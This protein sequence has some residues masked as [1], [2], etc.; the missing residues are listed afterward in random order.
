MNSH[1]RVLVTAGNTRERIDNVRDW[2]NIFTGNTGLEI[3][4]AIAATGAEVDLLTS[5]A[6][7]RE[8]VAQH[9]GEDARIRPIAFG[10]HAQLHQALQARVTTERYDAVFMT[11]AVADYRPAGGYQVINRTLRDDGTEMWIV[12]SAQAGKIKSNFDQIAF[13]GERTQ[14]L[15]DLFRS[16]WGYGGLLVKF[17]LEVGISDEQLLTVARASRVASGAQYIVANTLEMVSGDRPGAYI[18]GE[19]AE[20]WVARERLAGE[21]AAIAREHHPSVLTVEV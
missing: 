2:G 12:Q 3:A 19:H 20:R 11:A 10:S 14:K 16:Q 18:V 13:L 4:R 1:L 9:R 7:H 5:N 15:V 8:R 17:K 21:L 6:V